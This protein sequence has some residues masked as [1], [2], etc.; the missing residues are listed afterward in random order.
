MRVSYSILAAWE[1]RDYDS[2]IGMYLG[3]KIQPTRAMMAGSGWHKEWEEETLRT[4][5]LPAIFGARELKNPETEVKIV[6]KLTPWLTLSG[7][8]DLRDVPIVFEYKTGH[9]PA[10]VWARSKQHLV[11]QILDPRL[12]LAEYFAYNQHINNVT[13]ERVHL[14]KASLYEGMNWVI[15][16]S[17]EMKSTLDNLGYE[18]ESHERAK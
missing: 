7:V 1:R 10:A 13:Y 2:A 11:Y 9:S 8:M 12:T 14:T 5:K 16:L 17:S 3:K 6:K 18:T 15:T 4:G